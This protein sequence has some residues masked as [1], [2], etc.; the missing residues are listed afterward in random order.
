MAI[1]KLIHQTISSKKDL[2]PVFL[3][4][5]ARMQSLN[6]GWEHHL[7]DEDE[8]REFISAHYGRD[9]L[10]S[11]LR[12]NPSYGP[13]KAD[14]FRYLLLYK[15]GG[16]YLDLKST[17]TQKLDDVLRADDAY[18]L[19]QWPDQN[20]TGGPYDG[21]GLHP[22]LTGKGE[23]QIWHI[24]AAPEHPFLE[25]VIQSVK[26]NIDDYDPLR[27]GVA[28][29]AV[30]RVTGPIAYTLAIQSVQERHKYRYVDIGDLGFRCSIFDDEA[31]GSGHV[32]YF[33][34][35]YRY[36]PEPLVLGRPIK[37][38]DAAEKVGRNDLC[39][40]GSGKK[41]KHCHGRS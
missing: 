12:I 15:K 17:V 31:S 18:L 19:S 39:P 26:R 28:K 13:A 16:V 34:K 10:E 8:R 2:Q 38:P 37:K 21:W 11:Y 24:V 40:C 5:I 22:E 3:E 23:Y 36:L 33:K 41:Y 29:P 7:Y 4:N 20:E 32:S 14:F 1:P 30:L 6:S 27:D 9:V 25:A 35:H